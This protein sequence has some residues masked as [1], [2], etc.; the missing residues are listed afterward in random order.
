M[1]F[2]AL[3]VRPD[4]VLTML[5]DARVLINDPA[6]WCKGAF[7]NRHRYC[8]IGALREVSLDYDAQR[9]ARRQLAAALPDNRR[10]VVEFNDSPHT[11][12]GMILRLFDR[13][14]E[15]RV[16]MLADAVAA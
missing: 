5:T 4:R 3:P 10:T 16:K 15:A 7:Y 8:A 9:D 2:D 14:I 13:A 6:H 11:T 1:P 12:H